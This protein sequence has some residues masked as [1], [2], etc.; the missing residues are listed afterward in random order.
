MIAF[1]FPYP[2]TLNHLYGQRR[3]GGK[4]IKPPGVA[5]K[6]EVAEIVAHAGHKLISGPVA[7]FVAAH[8]PDKRR[9]DIMNLEK[10]LSD[11]MT[12]AGVWVDDHQVHDF[13]IVKR[14]I[15][16]GGLVRVV[17]TELEPA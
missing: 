3:N 9:R 1:T 7:V 12:S 8:M 4:F 11:S 2:P 16:K 14:E 15:I 13:H 10:I 6:R 5:F 17:V